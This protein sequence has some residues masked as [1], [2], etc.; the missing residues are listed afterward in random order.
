[1]RKLGEIDDI[2]YKLGLAALAVALAAAL[3]YCV[4]GFSVL[5]IKFPCMFKTVTGLWC[6]G[7]GG[8][9]ALKQLLKG[10]LWQSFIDYPPVIY[11]AVVY[12]VFMIRCFTYRHG[13]HKNDRRG[14]RLP[15]IFGNAGPETADGH[16]EERP[17][18][19]YKDGAVLPYIYAGVIMGLLQW[20]V[21]LI[22]LVGFGVSWVK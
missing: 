13:L 21:K 1:M 8:T 3:L 17:K 18:R 5:D 2:F 4:T 6:P 9:R 12:V 10:N 20:V 7:C 22:A 16:S 14:R 15:I 11:G 19:V